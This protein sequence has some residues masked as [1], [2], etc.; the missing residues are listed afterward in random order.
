MEPKHIL[1]VDDEPADL[2][3]LSEILTAAGYRVSKAQSGIEGLKLAKKGWVDL[4]IV[5]LLMPGLDGYSLIGMLTRDRMFKSP[6]LVISGRVEERDAQQ[7]LDAG[8]VG[9]IAKPVEPDDL[10][11]R[12]AKL[13]Q[14]DASE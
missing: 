13:L 14:Q 12:V 10:V 11:A 5:D 2:E 8:A 9:F 3:V 4:A 1:V 7:A 6:V